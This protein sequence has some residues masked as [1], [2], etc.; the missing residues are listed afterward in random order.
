M[1]VSHQINC[2]KLKD[3]SSFFIISGTQIYI[4]SPNHAF[5]QH[6]SSFYSQCEQFGKIELALIFSQIAH[7]YAFA[8]SIYQNY[9]PY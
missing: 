9:S 2:P 5:S 4:G 3:S 6:L 8:A 7:I 1:S